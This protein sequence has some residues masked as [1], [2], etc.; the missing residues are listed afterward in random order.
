M[1]KGQAR[2]RV[3]E[4]AYELIKGIFW[5]M[6]CVNNITARWLQAVPS[7]ITTITGFVKVMANS[8]MYG[9]LQFAM[10]TSGISFF[11]EVDLRV[12]YEWLTHQQR[13][14]VFYLFRERKQIFSLERSLGDGA[15]WAGRSY[16]DPKRLAQL[17][18]REGIV[19]AFTS[20]LLAH[21]GGM[22]RHHVWLAFSA[23]CASKDANNESFVGHMCYAL[24]HPR[25]TRD[26]LLMIPTRAPPVEILDADCHPDE[27]KLQVVQGAPIVNSRPTTAN[28]K[29]NRTIVE[30]QQPIDEWT[31]S[32]TRAL[33]GWRVHSLLIGW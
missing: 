26:E 6:D 11:H 9:A 22:L 8:I 28:T 30:E 16:L 14:L 21:E 12:R 24:S 29:R 31:G 3:H 15:F 33:P 5:D 23:L 13:C 32:K 17:V 27:K 18:H 25:L 7:K 2:K 10:D 19:L 4:A 20:H 1:D